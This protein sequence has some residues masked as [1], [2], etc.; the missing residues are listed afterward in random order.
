MNFYIKISKSREND[1][2][3]LRDNLIALYLIQEIL[4]EYLLCG[5]LNMQILFDNRVRNILGTF[6]S[7]SRLHYLHL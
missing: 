7:L 4:D 3:I 5:R 2:A 6:S 1:G